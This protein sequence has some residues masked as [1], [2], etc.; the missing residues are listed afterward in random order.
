MDSKYCQY[1]YKNQEKC[2]VWI[3]EIDIYNEI[4]ISNIET[5]QI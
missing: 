4:H 3:G 2:V 5:T 1:L